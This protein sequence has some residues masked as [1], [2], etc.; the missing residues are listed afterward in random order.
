MTLLCVS[1]YSLWLSS[2][3]LPTRVIPGTDPNTLSTATM[4]PLPTGGP[5]RSWPCGVAG[6]PL[7]VK[8][9]QLGAHTR[10]VETSIRAL[11]C[12]ALC[13]Q[14]DSLARQAA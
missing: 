3:L 9:E 7:A 8:A 14:G 11:I 5:L 12:L 4:F 10:V 6:S 2:S 13:V 1:F